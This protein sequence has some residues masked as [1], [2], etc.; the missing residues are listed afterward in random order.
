VVV[1][2]NESGPRYVRHYHAEAL[3]PEG[4]R[5]LEGIGHGF[6][7]GG[8]DLDPAAGLVVGD[9]EVEGLEYL[10]PAPG[11]RHMSRIARLMP[12]IWIAHGR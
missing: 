1:A 11:A 4:F 12:P 10:A 2:R 5:V 9:L 8:R 7:D 3:L 6:G